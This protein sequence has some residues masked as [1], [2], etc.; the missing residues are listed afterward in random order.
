[1]KPAALRTSR[2]PGKAK[3]SPEST[4][5]AVCGLD[6]G[7]NMNGIVERERGFDFMGVATEMGTDRK[8]KNGETGVS[9][10]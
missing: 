3:E 2:R 6:C 8:A 4:L 1:M 10:E 5:I 7:M 9:R